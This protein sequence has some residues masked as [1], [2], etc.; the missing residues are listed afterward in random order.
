LSP[1]VTTTSLAP[2]VCGTTRPAGD[3]FAVFPS[4][5]P[6][7][8]S[9]VRSTSR[10]SLRVAVTTSW[11]VSSEPLRATLAGWTARALI[12]PD[13]GSGGAFATDG[14]AVRTRPAITST[15]ARGR[16]RV[17]GMEGTL[18]RGCSGGIS[19]TAGTLWQQVDCRSETPP[20]QE[21]NCGECD[22]GTGQWVWRAAT[23]RERT[24]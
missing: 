7:C 11:A 2:F 1:K 17:V 5:T 15:A 12:S 10:P 24:T 16:G 8:T 22:S 14:L 4:A 20:G 18:T 19:G 21:V 6:Y 13:F 23:A 9:C 3:T